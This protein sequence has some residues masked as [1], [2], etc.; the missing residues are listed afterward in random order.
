MTLFL[1]KTIVDQNNNRRKIV[2]QNVDTHN[3]WPTC[4]LVKSSY[5][6]QMLVWPTF[7]S[8]MGHGIGFDQDILIFR[9]DSL[10]G[11]SFVEIA[12]LSRFLDQSCECNSNLLWDIPHDHGVFSLK[13]H[14]HTHVSHW[15]RGSCLKGAVRTQ[16]HLALWLS[17]LIEM[18]WGYTAGHNLSPLHFNNS[19]NNAS[20]LQSL[21]RISGLL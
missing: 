9:G 16:L 13:T 6:G 14:G 10:R 12:W 20:N 21:Y 8:R 18:L 7:L 1:K 19:N 5:L 17:R 11:D 15:L 2:P 3:L 4:R